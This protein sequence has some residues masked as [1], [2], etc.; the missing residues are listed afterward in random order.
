[1]PVHKMEV[2]QCV[3]HINDNITCQK[4]ASIFKQNLE[5]KGGNAA[6]KFNVDAL[7]ANM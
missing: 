7:W 5:D 2:S 6:W 1:M 3:K 4:W